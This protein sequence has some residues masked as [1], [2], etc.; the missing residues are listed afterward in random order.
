MVNSDNF[1]ARIEY[2][3]KRR[4][5]IVAALRSRDF[6]KYILDIALRDRVDVSDAGR[7]L[8]AGSAVGR[9]RHADRI[10][11][12]TLQFGLRRNLNIGGVVIDDPAKLFR[13]KEE[14]L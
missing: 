8:C 13:E 2:A 14:R 10:R 6:G 5:Q 3:P 4:K 9:S 7:R 1:L 12:I 11:E